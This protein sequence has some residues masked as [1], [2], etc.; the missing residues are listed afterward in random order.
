[1][2]KKVLL[3]AGGG[4]LGTY[5]AQELLEMGRFVD[6]LCL[7][8]KFSDNDK[9][10][11]YKGCA[12]EEYLTTLLA[13]HHYDGIVNFVHYQD[14]ESYRPIHKLLTKHTEHLIFL[15]SYRVY[16]DKEH[17]IKEESPMLLDVTE[18]IE[19]KQHEKYAIVKAKCEKFLRDEDPNGNWTIVRPVI[20]FSKLRFDFFM[21]SGRDVLLYARDGKTMIMPELARNFTAGLDWSGN[22]G[23]IIAHLLFKKETIGEA[24]TISSAPGLTWGE[25]AKI[26]EEHIGLKVMWTD[27]ETYLKA[28]PH[29]QREKGLWWAYLYDRKFDRAVDN[30]KVLKATGLGKKDFLSLSEG[31][32][33]E[34]SR[35]EM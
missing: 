2:Q 34:I 17:P 16:A 25:I 22:T 24:Y 26:Y 32:D 12:T 23:K 6:V 27:E 19:F 5:V 7:E 31:L 21:Y 9:L 29:L 18:D 28:N 14:V 30:T 4:T 11:F 8:D 1:M 13:E 20:S 15:S 3:I 35:L 10:T 33:I